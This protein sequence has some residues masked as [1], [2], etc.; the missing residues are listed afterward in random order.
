MVR[1]AASRNPK[2]P[3][4]SHNSPSPGKAGSAAALPEAVQ[5]AGQDREVELGAASLSAIQQLIDSGI[6]RAVASF[7]AKFE[8]LEKRISILECEGMS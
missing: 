6:A 1:R 8:H 4:P 5:P 7:E 2:R 3:A